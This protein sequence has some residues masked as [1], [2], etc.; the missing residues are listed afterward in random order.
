VFGTPLTDV[1]NSIHTPCDKTLSSVSQITVKSSSCGATVTI[2]AAAED[3]LA[4][5][6]SSGYL[7]FA[8]T[9]GA[10]P[11]VA[12]VAALLQAI[13]P[14][15]AR[16]TPA[17]VKTTIVSTADDIDTS[18]R[19]NTRVSSDAP[20]MRRV[21]ALAAV[22]AILPAP[23][24]PRVFV[25][26]ERAAT[27]IGLSIDPLT[28]ERRLDPD[29]VIN[30][31]LNGI[32]GVPK[33]MVF[34]PT[35]DIVYVV[36]AT[37]DAFGDGVM[38]VNTARR[39][40]ERFLAFSGAEDNAPVPRAL[41]IGAAR[42]GMA[43]TPDG[44][45]LYVSFGSRLAIFNTVERHLV[46]T[47]GDLPMPYKAADTSISPTL[48]DRRLELQ[49]FAQ[50]I[51]IGPDGTAGLGSLAISPDGK[52]L[53]VTVT[54][55]I[56]GGAQPGAVMPVNIDLYT[57]T[58]P[59]TP[60]LQLD[61]SRYLARDLGT[62]FLKMPSATSSTS[63][64]ADSDA[65]IVGDEPSSVAVSPD[66]KRLYLVNS[67]I[68]TYFS[69]DTTSAGLRYQDL[70]DGVERVQASTTVTLLKSAD[71]IGVFDAKAGVPR[72]HFPSKIV[73]GWNPDKEKGGQ[74]VDQFR[75]RNVFAK[76]PYSIAFRPDGRRAIVSFH[77]TGNFGIL[78]LDSQAFFANPAV[79]TVTDQ[80]SAVVAVTRAIRFDN[81]LW[82]RNPADEARLYAT[83][84]A[85]AQNGTF[86]VGIH[87]G[88][89]EGEVTGGGVTILKDDEITLDLVANENETVVGSNGLLRPYFTQEGVC[90]EIAETGA[91]PCS[92][93]LK[94]YRG[95]TGSEILFRRPSALA[96]HPTLVVEGPFYGDP[97]SP[98]TAI[99]LRWFGITPRRIRFDVYDLGIPG[100][101]VQV[102]KANSQHIVSPYELPTG[103]FKREFS[104][105]YANAEDNHLYRIVITALGAS[106]EPLS[107]TS[108]DVGFHR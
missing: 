62:S 90:S 89:G 98:G 43:L 74:I 15:D 42:P 53:F 18:W 95:P 36:V 91:P 8:G 75:F 57:D 68:D 66:G 70:I 73:F 101:S 16:Y 100:A 13:R 22:R 5:S 48:D 71:T 50:T 94:S 107:S 54:N 104:A 64:D 19:S 23:D 78:D 14:H 106:N 44:R 6:A 80:F 99:Q 31:T 37:R 35:G 103:S 82:P 12:G 105:L 1:Y 51:A 26:D 93:F 92:L 39:R 17:D 47:F 86:A 7:A 41:R 88:A 9:S 56:G 2:A 21:N 25:A 79:T 84:V 61:Y 20:K 77:Q 96:I 81:H 87:T 52:T 108:I 11:L 30:L 76:R 34:S 49:V 60:G 65:S 4:V 83:Q 29:T 97:I 102:F 38:I 67:G 59:A 10:A 58:D 45:L 85:Y 69:L 46:T 63:A 55:G 72:R 32:V 40:V 33:A 27:L 3:V 28:G 24:A